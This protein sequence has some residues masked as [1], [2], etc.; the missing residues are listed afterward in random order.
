MYQ[1]IFSTI[2][3]SC[4]NPPYI[5]ID[6]WIL[7]AENQNVVDLCSWCYGLTPCYDRRSFIFDLIPFA[8]AFNI[9]SASAF[10]CGRFYYG[11]NPI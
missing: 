10:A 5:V 3:V 4:T 9:I 7:S 6:M 8:N 2:I 1:L 11:A